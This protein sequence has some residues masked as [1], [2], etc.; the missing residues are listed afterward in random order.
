M[1]VNNVRQ[2]RQESFPAVSHTPAQESYSAGIGTIPHIPLKVLTAERTHL[3]IKKLNF[4]KEHEMLTFI[5]LAYFDQPMIPLRS[6]VGKLMNVG[7]VLA[8]EWL[9]YK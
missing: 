1:V 2:R 4:E 6:N 9:V 8:C 3:E 5:P 7:Y